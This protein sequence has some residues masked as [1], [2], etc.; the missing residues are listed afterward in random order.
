MAGQSGA[1][2]LP[3][4]VSSPEFWQA[5]ADSVPDLL[6]LV[7]ER[8]RIL[9]ANRVPT[10]M[11]PGRVIG[12]SVLDFVPESARNELRESLAAIFRGAPARRREQQAILG[13]GIISWFSTHTSPVTFDGR[14][15]AALVVARDI[16]ERRHAQQAL[17]E[18]EARFRTLVE[19]APEA[20][21][22][23]DVDGNRFVDAN[24]NACELF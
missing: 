21:V 22:V 15:V 5:V 19:H 6:L 10:G 9:H 23:L 24:R 13:D 18:S 17:V 14:I 11:Q 8:G 4:E 12:A 1:G 3:P 2:G 16:T 7:D 20:I